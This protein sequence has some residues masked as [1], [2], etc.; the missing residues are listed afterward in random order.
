MGKDRENSVTNDFMAQLLKFSDKNNLDFRFK[1]CTFIEKCSGLEL[2]LENY[3]FSHV[4]IFF[5]RS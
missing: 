4:F 5:R 2:R 1:I 3:L